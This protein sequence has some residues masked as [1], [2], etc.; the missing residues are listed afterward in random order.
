MTWDELQMRFPELRPLKAVPLLFN[1]LGCGLL[2]YGARD[3][4]AETST[5]VK[6][7]YLCL[8]GIPLLALGSY[9]V[10][11]TPRGLL[12]VGREP[13]SAA[14]V[15]L[16]VVVLLAGIGGAACYG[17]HELVTSEG[18]V[19]RRRLERADGLV[20]SGHL[21]D[22]AGLYEQVA[23]GGTDSAATAVARLA[24]LM[25]GP[26]ARP[27]PEGLA[28]VFRAGARLV[29][30]RRWPKH[31]ASPFDAGMAAVNAMAPSD[32]RGAVLVLEAVAQ[33]AG[34]GDDTAALAVDLLERVVAA[35]PGD[36]AMASR[37]AVRYEGRNQLDR[38][39]KLL[40]P[41]RDRLGDS[42]G[43]RVLGLIDAKA[44]RIEPALAL[45]DA[46]ARPRLARLRAAED[47]L[48]AA[49]HAAEERLLERLKS[50][51]AEDFDYGAARRGG[52]EAADAMVNAYMNR[53]LKDDPEIARASDSV[54]AESP[55]AIVA[56]EL[57]MLRLQH[58]QGL[59]D[60][61]ARKRELEA[62]EAAFLAVQRRAGERPEFQLS[63]GQVYYWEGKSKEGRAEFDKLLAARHRDPELLLT[64]ADTLRDVGS[65]AEAREL[66]EEGFQKATAPA[67]RKS[68]ATLRGL[69]AI[70]SDERLE[71]LQKGDPTD[72]FARALLNADL[73]VK[74][75]REGDPDAAIRRL[76]E[77]IRLYEGLPEGA[78][79]LNNL[80]LDLRLLAR[81]TGEEEL[82][83]RAAS[84]IERAAA[85]TPGNSLTLANAATARLEAALRDLIGTALDLKVLRQPA[86]L[87]LLQHLY[88]DRAG[89]D[90]FVRRVA[91]HPG[92]ARARALQQKV[93][94][95]APR[96]ARS[97][98]PELSIL[99]LIDDVAGLR[100]LRQRVASA[101]LDLADDLMEA[102]DAESGARDE[103]HRASWASTLKMAEG[104]LTDARALGHGPTLA[105]AIDSV[106]GARIGALAHGLEAD[107][108]A[109]VA[110]A[111]EAHE[112]AP[113]SGS[114]A[115]LVEAMLAR[116]EARLARQQPEYAEARERT[117]RSV[118]PG[119]RV[120]AVLSVDGPLARAVAADPDVI[121]A[122]GLVLAGFERDPDIAGP[123]A[124]AL[125]R[126]THPEAAARVARS[127]EA[128]EADH[129]A[130][131][132]ADGS[133]PTR[134]TAPCRRSGPTPWRAGTRRRRRR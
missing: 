79:T 41:L 123:R 134:P 14:A 18:F 40:E 11:R 34:K 47:G 7:R 46:Y 13:S 68:C 91:E 24:A 133:S 25:K 96:R 15:W 52:D 37:L 112:A 5:A 53:H 116:A 87:G 38:C 50:G 90:A 78:A 44:D 102:R 122:A 130:Q 51:K 6:T 60:P 31:E 36:V 88:D 62:A 72:P 56:L 117:R 81:L 57:G 16:N 84:K 82:Y 95:L 114:R 125:L 8:F 92:V 65:T 70:D 33:L 104:R 83:E 74:S 12:F 9:R 75:L 1:L 23:S 2:L 59:A 21:A 120:A 63:L 32:P 19:A 115:T 113:S 42:E 127:Y 73:A 111:R 99:G 126:L 119:D 61:A 30:A 132:S 97:Y 118:A 35:A 27:D 109:L 29:R 108:D 105:L 69:L 101:D 94:L 80:S 39:A 43:A 26:G 67:V 3:E 129:L 93:I 124:W 128:R 89:R 71:W 64:I 58:A 66:A 4:D 131:R 49:I 22:A 10:A 121:G 28:A 17:V 20:G 85:L 54:E 100:A 110:M 77:S 86:E 55:V 107:L 48:Q 45:L 98:Q 103:S 106:V 76:R